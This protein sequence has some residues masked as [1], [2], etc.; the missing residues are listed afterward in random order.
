VQGT[1]V[2]ALIRELDDPERPGR[3][4][5]S[6]R[7]TDG[8]VDVSA[9]ARAQGGGGHRRAAGFSSEDSVE[10]VIAFLRGEISAQLRGPHAVSSA[11]P[12]R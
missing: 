7:S 4:K 10:D 1:R 2:A 5:I 6:L 12:H 8:S 11:E 9:I 3:H